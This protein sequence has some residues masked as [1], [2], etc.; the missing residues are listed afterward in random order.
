MY[1]RNMTRYRK[2]NHM[3]LLTYIMCEQDVEAYYFKLQSSWEMVLHN[4]M[5]MCTTS[6]I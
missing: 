3:L 6:G 1:V 5:Y 4:I 2:I